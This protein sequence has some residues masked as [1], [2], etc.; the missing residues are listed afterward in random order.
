MIEVQ[1]L[2]KRYGPVTAVDDISFTVERG[3]I[4]GFLGPNGAGKTTT[5]RVL[6]GYMPPTGGKAIVAGYDVFEQPIEAKRRIGYLPETPPLYPDMTVREYL[7]FVAKIKG[8]AR[9]ER[10][11]RVEEMMRKTHILD[12]SREIG[13]D[14]PIYPGH[15]KVAFWWHLTHDEVKHYR[16]HPESRFGGYAV[17]GMALCD[18]VSTHI[19]AVYHFNRN[20]PDLTVER[21]GLETLITPG[22]WIDL[23]SVPPRTHITL[24]HVQRALSGAGV[25]LRPGMTLLCYTGASKHWDD[26]VRFN[27]EYPG[28]DEE[29]SRWLLDQG[30]VNVGTDAPSTDNPADTRYPNHLVHGERCVP[31]TEI[32]ANIHRIPRH[33]GFSVMILPLRFEGLTGSPVRALALWTDE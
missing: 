16:I 9:A 23:S 27:S 18:H 15:A 20:R 3:E 24:P 17:K 22:A 33:T 10:K 11:A 28:F 6:T 31:H 29:A 2:T 19:D 26:P 32:L 13:P 5:M 1:H 21:I 14:I 25:T 12:L 4:L 7:S 30:L 8:V